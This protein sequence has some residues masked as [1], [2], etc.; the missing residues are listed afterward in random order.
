[1]AFNNQ[2]RN[3]IRVDGED[4]VN[5]AASGRT[6]MGRLISVEWCKR[7]FVPHLGGF[8]SARAFANYMISG[9]DDKLR[10]STKFYKTDV[11]ASTVRKLMVFGKY[12]QLLS[13]RNTMI[14]NS[15]AMSLP[16]VSYRQYDSGVRE[17]DRWEG[18]GTLIK[19]FVDSVISNPPKHR[20]DWAGLDPEVLEEV[21]YCL[22]VIVGD[23]YVPFET[24]TAERTPTQRKSK[25]PKVSEVEEDGDEEE[26]SDTTTGLTDTP[27]TPEPEE[28]AEVKESVTEAPEEPLYK[29]TW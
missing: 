6:E 3:I 16:W 7:F 20:Y 4:H 27:T 25:E 8:S 5:I 28:P 24:L 19:R 21:N 12:Y 17:H 10:E 29:Q 22:S 14:A 2:M 1:M 13:L 11:P 18:Y 26:L 15:D 9:G 23:G